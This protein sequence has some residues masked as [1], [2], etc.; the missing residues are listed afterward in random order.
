[1]GTSC[2]RPESPC[3]SAE[4]RSGLLK[5]DGKAAGAAGT[6]AGTGPQ[7]ENNVR[8][9]TDDETIKAEASDDAQVTVLPEFGTSEPIIAQENGS[10]RKAAMQ[11]NAPTPNKAAAFR[12][13]NTGTF[14]DENRSP[15]L[16]QEMN[17]QGENGGRRRAS[18]AQGEIQDGGAEESQMSPREG[19]TNKSNVCRREGDGRGASKAADSVALLMELYSK[20][21]QASSSRDTQGA[22]VAATRQDDTFEP[23]CLLNEDSEDGNST[24]LKSGQDEKGHDVAVEPTEAKPGGGER[25]PA[26]FND[27]ETPTAAPGDASG[28]HAVKENQLEDIHQHAV[29]DRD[30]GHPAAMGGGDGTEEVENAEGEEEMLEEV[31]NEPVEVEENTGGTPQVLVE[32]VTPAEGSLRSSEEDLYRAE[33]LP[34]SH[35]DAQAPPL[36]STT[37]EARCSLGPVVDIL[38][39]SEREWR[40][41]TAK[42]ALIR[43]G[44]K[45]LSQSFAGVRQVRGDNYC[46][47][48][49]T[50]FQVLSQAS[51]VPAWL[52]ED[53]V[54]EGLQDLSELMAL[55]T[56]PGEAQAQ[57][58]VTQRLQSCVEILRNKLGFS[59]KA[60]SLAY[61]W[62]STVARGGVLR[63]ARRPPT[64]VRRRL[65][66]WRGGA[67]HAGGAQATHA[68]PRR[69]VEHQHARRPGRAALQLAAVRARLLRLPAGL[70]RQ[71]P[72][73]RGRRRRTGAG[74]DVPAG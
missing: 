44:Y 10:L 66:G 34:S 27:A 39:Y 42:S 23:N 3:G 63:F 31:E 47:L 50:L 51:Q 26:H 40:G 55:W 56:F 18:S 37:L 20:N 7:G 17:C 45:E 52:Q 57:P 71:P 9:T 14:R 19:A 22:P 67:R 41:N 25:R 21:K 53:D 29:E 30:G 72:E 11:S 5:D 49:A 68:A 6:T 70:P 54:G 28:L 38:S 32:E 61:P 8:K 46:A 74:G 73:P 15:E 16:P 13:E 62:S 33:E 64:T 59:N 65:P 4:E 1:M 43:K 48:R 12:E 2:C 36:D 58:D 69:R 35:S 60:L 24:E